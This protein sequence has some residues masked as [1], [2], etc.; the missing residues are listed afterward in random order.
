MLF[1]YT[2]FPVRIPTVAANNAKQVKATPT[3]MR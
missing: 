1:V 3:F 2:L